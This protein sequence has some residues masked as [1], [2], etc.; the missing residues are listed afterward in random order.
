MGRKKRLP[1]LQDV[2]TWGEMTDNQV[3]FNHNGTFQKTYVFR[4]ADGSNMTEDGINSYYVG[5]NNIFMRLKRN[6]YVFVE[7]HKRRT[8]DVVHSH[9]DDDILQDFE[10][11]RETNIST[12]QIYDNEFYLTICYKWPSEVMQRASRI[13]DKS[14]K[15]IL[16][17]L[18]GAVKEFGAVFNPLSSGLDEIMKDQNVTYDHFSEMESRFLEECETLV[19]GLADYFVEIHPCS[20]QETLTYLHDCISDHHMTVGSHIRNF[21]TDRIKDSIFLGGRFPKLG[22]KYLG[23]VGVKDVPSG[24]IDFMFDRLNSLSIE[25]RFV[26]RYIAL[27]KQ[28]AINET[29]TIEAQHQQR[30]KSIITVIMETI[31]NKETGK[32]DRGAVIDSE[33]AQEAYEHLCKD[34]FGLGY[35]T[36]NIVVLNPDA[37]KLQEDLKN[38]ITI[39]N[40]LQCVAVNEKD[41]A[42]AAWLSS[43]PSNYENN[44]RSYLLTSTN[45]AN[46]APFGSYYSGEKKNRF[47]AELEETNHNPNMKFID[48]PL[49]QCSTPEHL[50]FFFNL[51]VGD[52]G[53]T[54]IVGPT[55][56][57]KSVLLNTISSNFRK[58]PNCKVF[59]FDKSASSRVLTRAIGGNFYNLLVDST[60]I[61]FQPLANIDQP[62]EKT[63]ILEWLVNYLEAS[64]LKITPND[65]NT[66]LD[67]LNSVAGA[68]KEERT[69]TALITMMQDETIR[70]GLRDLSLKGA[71]GALFDSNDDK[72]GSGRWQVFE[73]EKLMENSKIVAPTLDYLFHRIEGQLDGSPALM[74]LDECW[75][76][77]RNDAFRAKIVEYLKDLRKKNCA[78]VM[79]TQNL[80]DMDEK[81]IPVVSS[82]CLTKIFLPNSSINDLAYEM[83]QRFDLNDAEISI[84]GDIK[85]KRQYF[86]KSSLGTRV[87]DLTLS[88]LELAF[89]GATSKEDQLNVARMQDLSREEFVRRW[90][91][92]KNVV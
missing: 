69:I 19:K 90:K 52:V 44:V 56:S 17:E 58:Y 24:T 81:L 14:N 33:D 32:V 85:P 91:K 87:F 37:Q 27:D 76:F 65:R 6:Y 2:V 13:L 4:G 79:A 21:I 77:L 57:G 8:D 59:V 9:F 83:Y 22:E 74:I 46:M 26:I 70:S 62:T 41:N 67:A 28:Q 12:H 84:L 38:V 15:E 25:Y 36:A 51:H 3:V 63:W 20:E 92:L 30:Q 49:F 53:H 54:L 42:T 5:L 72:F 80:S 75:L 40:D 66:I 10:K 89:L 34:D 71:Y 82:N 23:V 1:R 86:Y 60:S 11:E 43:L 68:P 18:K 7:M 35:L 45:F 61:S 78:V 16:K 48:D 55:G 47:F 73:M 29:K 31:N 39:V 50:P 64:N 88:P